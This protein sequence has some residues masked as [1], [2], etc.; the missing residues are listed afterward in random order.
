MLGGIQW[1]L[2][3]FTNTVVIPLSVGAAFH[4]SPDSITASLQRSFIFTGIACLLQAFWGH[5][6]SLM[7]G[8]SG[9]WWGVILSLCATTSATNGSFLHLGGALS[10]GIIISGALI[11]ILGL[12]GM[13]EILK[14]LF[15]PI[16]M[17]VFLFLLGSQLISIFF[18]GMIGLSQSNTINLAT[19]ILSLALVGLVIALNITKSRFLSNFAILIGIV[20]GWMTY[21]WFSPHSSGI[22]SGIATHTHSLSEIFPF[23]KPY[24][25]L[26]IISTA[27]LTG[28]INTTNTIASLRGSEPI[29]RTTVDANQYRRSFFFTGLYSI[30]SGI[31]GMVPYAPYTSSLGFLRSTRI[32]DRLP[33]AIGA[34]MFVILG[35]IPWLGRF[36]ST[37]PISVG[38]AVLF[39]AYLQLFGAALQNVEGIRFTFQTIY[40][41]ATPTLLGLAIMNLSPGV[42]STL[43]SLLRP[44]VSNGL[45]LGILLSIIM[46]NCINW[47]RF[48]EKV[49]KT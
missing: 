18:K 7:E 20:I 33:F 19:A 39:V 26:G 28:L 48:E 9:L 24:F 38:D 49:Y 16:V 2:F 1:L 42:F 5:R 43:P 45:L 22:S 44:I 21:S 31:F 8:Q 4:Q 47:D 34:A 32:L 15:S 14:R 12:L 10:V 3:M 37:L 40:R 6:L 36:F 41:I 25:D 35:V 13:G 27:I 11:V 46:E 23:G 29:Y 17:S 30:V